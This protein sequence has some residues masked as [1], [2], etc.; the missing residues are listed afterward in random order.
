MILRT[1]LADT[2]KD[3]KL[4]WSLYLINILQAELS[5]L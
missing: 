3:D 1:S 2:D 5:I 4:G